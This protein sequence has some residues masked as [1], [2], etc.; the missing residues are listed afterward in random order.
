MTPAS[1]SA[2]DMRR[3]D[4]P[5]RS[6]GS[7]LTRVYYPLY[8]LLLFSSAAF[9]SGSF[10]GFPYKY[11][12]TVATAGVVIL[13]I[14]LE[15]RTVRLKL[16]LVGGSL[17]ALLGLAS[18]VGLHNGFGTL[19]LLELVGLVSPVLLLALYRRDL[20]A[21]RAARRIILSGA[22]VYALFKLG[23]ALL[24]VTGLSYNALDNSIE[25]AFG[26]GFISQPIAGRLLR[27]YAANDLLLATAPL[28]LF[29][30]RSLRQY[31]SSPFLG[32][33]ILSLIPFPKG[34][35]TL[36]QGIFR[37][38][39]L[40]LFAAAVFLSYS[41]FI[42]LLFALSTAVALLRWLEPPLHLGRASLALLG[43][44]GVIILL[45]VNLAAVT[46]AAEPLWLRFNP[47][48]SFNT[49]SDSIRSEQAELMLDYLGERPLQG[50]GLGA[51][52][53][54]LIRAPDQP[55]S[56]ELQ[57]LAFLFK[58]GLPLFILTLSLIGV[59]L[60]QVMAFSCYSLLMVGALFA[61]GLFNPYLT[62]SLFGVALL[63]LILT[64]G[65]PAAVTSG[66]RRL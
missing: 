52:M 34:F 56:Y 11:L 16:V 10:Y 64:F 39:L 54:E 37:V 24:V 8:G 62:S 46:A 35:K 30:S 38:L 32:V 31:P 51:Y 3:S 12:L 15:L 6:S 42:F 17:A 29:A 45:I 22:S 44:C 55:Y 26:I 57:L 48:T 21:P 66:A 61:C 43:A 27:L 18:W 23:A 50:W 36:N 20:L 47:N 4:M 9:I 14:A 1:V 63:G 19:V 59:Y 2:K 7:F 5:S 53:R 28:L 65:S 58:L 13:Y 60:R 41:R 25:G 40:G 49:S 33:K